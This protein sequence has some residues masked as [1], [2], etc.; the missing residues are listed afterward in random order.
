MSTIGV[1]DGS[2]IAAI[3][4]LHIAKTASQLAS[5][6]DGVM[7]IINWAS[8]LS[9]LVAP[10]SRISHPERAAVQMTAAVKGNARTVP[11]DGE[12]AVK[13]LAL[14]SER[15]KEPVSPGNIASDPVVIDFQM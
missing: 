13:G 1:A 2:I 10:H 14:I 4:T 6:H 11:L 3:M 12:V 15:S 7:G 8:G 5:D 9:M